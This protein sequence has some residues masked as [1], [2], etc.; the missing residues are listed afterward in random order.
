MLD[1]NLIFSHIKGGDIKVFERQL[2]YN[3][4]IKTSKHD[5]LYDE[6]KILRFKMNK[7]GIQPL[8]E[9]DETY[10]NKCTYS[11]DNKR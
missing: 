10:V 6:V 11:K 4:K 7:D 8:A 2:L 3:F 1:N 5:C 9:R